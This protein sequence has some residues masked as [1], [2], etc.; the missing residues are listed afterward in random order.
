MVISFKNDQ[1]ANFMSHLASLSICSCHQES[2]ILTTIILLPASCK[3][4]ARLRAHASLSFCLH[5]HILFHSSSFRPSTKK[6]WA[7]IILLS[8][9]QSWLPCGLT[10][11][12]EVTC[13]QMADHLRP[14][15]WMCALQPLKYVLVQHR[16]RFFRSLAT[17]S[18]APSSIRHSEETALACNH[19][20]LQIA[21]GQA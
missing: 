10:R 11:S 20:W 4:P 12:R 14:F 15:A 19:F 5:P 13:G 2:R 3:H 1:N 17:A 9:P 16:D 6:N 18:P 8:Q 21:P 7:V